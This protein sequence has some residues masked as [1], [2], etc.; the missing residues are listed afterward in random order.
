MPLNN[1]D[2]Y[3]YWRDEKLKHVISCVESCI[4]EIINPYKLTTAEKDKIQHLCCY[5]N[6]ALF[7]IKPQDDYVDAITQINH[8]VGLID[9]D[10]HL[11]AQ[12]NG[13][14]YITQSNDKKQ[15][16]FIPYTDKEISWHT[17]GYYN[18]IYNQVRAFSLFCV[19]PAATGGVNQWIDPQ[20]VYLLL[21]E[22]NADVV[23]ALS[24]PQA[25]SIP[26]HKVDG[27]VMRAQSTG[28]IFFIDEQSAELYMRY[29]QRKKNIE[30]L[31]SSEIKQAIALLDD[32]LGASTPY[33]FEYTMS[34]KQGLICNNILHNR[35]AFVDD[36]EQPRLL[37]R[38]RYFNRVYRY[39]SKYD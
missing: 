7:E 16:E 3:K 38:G 33:H 12:N 24:N 32:L 9:Y 30:F 27:Y 5:N 10:Q 11:Y 15:S 26:E 28:P 21:R 2:N 8:Q 20:M 6:F 19:Y 39:N 36:L 1:L 4:V 25:M 31:D 18:A 29:T 13:L 14:S 34:A 23:M 22:E 35:S 17:D 37:L